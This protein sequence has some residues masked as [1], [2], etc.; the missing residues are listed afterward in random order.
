MDSIVFLG[1]SLPLEEA[2]GLLKAEYRPPVQ[3]GDVYRAV[4]AKP[5]VIGIV[6]GYFE[7]VPAV[8]HKEVLWAMTQGIH[9]F[10]SASMGALRA[11]ELDQF[12]MEGVG[13]IYEA[14]RDGLIE[15][16]DEVAIR[17]ASQEFEFRPLSESM[18]NIRAT[19]ARAVAEYVLTRRTADKL[20]AIAKELF[21]PSRV[22]VTVL[23]LARDARLPEDELNAFERW[24]PSGRV[25]QKRDD[26]V[27]MLT[28][29]RDRLC[30]GLPPKRV[31]FEFEYTSLWDK[32]IRSSEMMS[33]L[34]GDQ[35][36]LASEFIEESRIE[37]LYLREYRLALARSL[38]LGEAFSQDVIVTDTLREELLS[39]FCRRCNLSDS[40]QLVQW[41]QNNDLTTAELQRFIDDEVRLEWT[42]R[43][44]ESD[45]QRLFMDQLR[46]DGLYAHLRD[47]ILDKRRRLAEWDWQGQFVRGGRL[48]DND[49]LRWY[50]IE[51]LGSSIPDS[52]AIY[53]A[54]LG[55]DSVEAFRQAVWREYVYQSCRDSP[56]SQ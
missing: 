52:V 53:A 35:R 10:G 56:A 39:A 45:V 12:G 46:A 44:Y 11:A 24:L 9:V 5:R 17:H 23:Q 20:D 32:A 40:S 34:D 31:Q 21:Y 6:D 26:A 47:K 36:T 25:N 8:W 33:P 18:V 50:F 2:Q 27:A 16:D 51:R 28:M 42:R 13:A 38:A 3:Q 55:F 29:M 41:M 30:T 14:Y 49:L 43:I 4:Q 37:G 7:S 48:N 1:P 15:D 22:Y 54:D 19:T